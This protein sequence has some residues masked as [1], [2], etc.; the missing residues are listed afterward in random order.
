MERFVFL[1]NKIMFEQK[2]SLKLY[3]NRVTWTRFILV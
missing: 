3:A 2:T 1:N